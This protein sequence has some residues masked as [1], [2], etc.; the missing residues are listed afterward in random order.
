MPEKPGTEPCDPLAD[1]SR[2]TLDRLDAFETLVRRWTPRINLIAPGAVDEIRHRHTCDS[3]QLLRLAP[4]EAE[5]WV[6]LGAGGG[7]P[8]VVIAIL[9][10]E[11]RPGLQ[12]AL[13]ESDARKC[14]FLEAA[15]RDLG[16]SA[17]VLR[18]RAEGAPDLAADVV[19]ARA[20]APL[21]KLVPL[22]LPW[23]KPGGIFL[24]PKGVRADDELTEARKCWHMEVDRI[25]SA[26]DPQASILRIKECRRAG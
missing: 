10:V 5:T 23:R 6:D 9:A 16:L 13:V 11:R 24:F 7:F 1:V 22:A 26:T 15:I 18:R 4:P 25:A 12:V 20:L 14:A 17:R 21:A 2:E 19:S 8:G 3:A